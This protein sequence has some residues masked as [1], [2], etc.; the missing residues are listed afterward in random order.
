MSKK[1]IKN[2]YID[3]GSWVIVNF[4]SSI[5]SSDTSTRKKKYFTVYRENG[6]EYMYMYV[7]DIYLYIRKGT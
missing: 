6:N 1:E 2:G 3:D 5:I 4:S 7:Y